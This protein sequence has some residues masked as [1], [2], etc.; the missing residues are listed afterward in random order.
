[1]TNLLHAKDKNSHNNKQQ[2][3]PLKKNKIIKL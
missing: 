1:M 3:N 2:Y